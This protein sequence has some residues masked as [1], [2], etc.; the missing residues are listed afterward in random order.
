[1]TCKQDSID[2]QVAECCYLRILEEIKYI[3]GLDRAQEH[4]KLP[5]VGSREASGEC[6][7]LQDGQVEARSTKRNP[8]PR[9]GRRKSTGA[10]SHNTNE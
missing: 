5:E 4:C 2:N 8:E 7:N 3:V 10:M 6:S 1:M 9:R